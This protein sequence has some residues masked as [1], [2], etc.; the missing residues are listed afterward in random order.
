MLYILACAREL[1]ECIGDERC[2]C[3]TLGLGPRASFYSVFNF[4]AQA[5]PNGYMM[6]VLVLHGS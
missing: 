5:V 2:G 6:R 3:I 4:D 1:S